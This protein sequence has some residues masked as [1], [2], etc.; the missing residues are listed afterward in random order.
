MSLRLSS[1]RRCPRPIN[2][3]VSQKK[4]QH[5]RGVSPLKFHERKYYSTRSL[6]GGTV[7]MQ[8]WPIRISVL[9]YKNI[10]FWTKTKMRLSPPTLKKAVIAEVLGLAWSRTV[11]GSCLCLSYKQLPLLFCKHLRPTILQM[12]NRFY[13]PSIKACHYQQESH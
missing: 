8:H 9:P 6:E 10:I 2:I 1:Y 3:F 4:S 5:F 13:K 11:A 12:P 7:E